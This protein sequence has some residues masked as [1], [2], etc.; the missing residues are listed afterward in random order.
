MKIELSTVFAPPHVDKFLF[1]MFEQGFV[2]NVF[3]TCTYVSKNLIRTVK[4]V[5]SF[6]HVHIGL[7]EISL[8]IINILIVMFDK[9]VFAVIYLL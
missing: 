1:K 4:G 7:T 9:I 3:I 6:E 8:F 5:Q 2:L